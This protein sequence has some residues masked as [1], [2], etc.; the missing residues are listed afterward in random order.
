MT[1]HTAAKTLKEVQESGRYFARN[2]DAQR[3]VE[4]LEWLVEQVPDPAPK[5][6]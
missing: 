2:K 6:K 4:V 5:G 1:K 3:L